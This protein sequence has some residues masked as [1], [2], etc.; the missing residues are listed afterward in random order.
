MGTVYEAVHELLDRPVA[1][2]VLAGPAAEDPQFLIRFRREAKAVGRLN[3]PNVVQPMDAGEVGGVPFLAMELL[4]GTDMGRLVRVLGPL[5]YADAAEVI[6]QAATALA[7]AHSKGLVHRDVKPSNLMLTTE[8]VVKLLDLGLALTP[9]AK[10]TGQEA[11]LTGPNFLGTHDYMAPEQWTDPSTVDSKADIYALG[12]VLYHLISGEPPFSGVRTSS[13]HAKMRAHLDSP[14]PDPTP[15][16]PELPPQL[17]AAI[18]VMMTKSPTDRPTANMIVEMLRDVAMSSHLTRLID[19]ST[20]GPTI[21]FAD[22]NPTNPA[23][24]MTESPTS[25]SSDTKPTI[26][27]LSTISSRKLQWRSW[28]AIGVSAVIGGGILAW[29]ASR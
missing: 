19:R 21:E 17:V 16:R 20:R 27:E 22:D 9:E 7:H 15:F 6:R 4:E 29:L 23:L 14:A 26:P 5:P 8:G 25:G 10:T 24:P 12:C 11:R 18:R 3:H 1:L 28:L 13:V 2:K